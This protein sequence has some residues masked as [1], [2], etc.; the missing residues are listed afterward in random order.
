MSVDLTYYIAQDIWE[1]IEDE[2]EANKGYSQFLARW[3]KNLLEEDLLIVRNII[4]EEYKH[5]CD[6][7][8]MAERLTGIKAEE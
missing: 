5:T 7:L 1:L 6:L 4:A 2:G 8:K 3:E